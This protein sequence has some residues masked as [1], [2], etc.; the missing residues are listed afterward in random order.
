MLCSSWGRK[1]RAPI[2]RRRHMWVEFVVGSL[3]CS[4]RF[5]SGYSGFALSLKSNKSEFK[6]DLE[7]T[8]TLCSVG[9]Q[10]RIPIFLVTA[11]MLDAEPE[12]R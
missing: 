12:R 7:R 6:F 9:K 1:P 5:F 11:L 4:E 2:W 8:D 10:I 3:L